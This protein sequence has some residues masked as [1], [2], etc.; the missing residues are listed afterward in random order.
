MLSDRNAENGYHSI[1]DSVP[2]CVEYQAEPTEA[3]G[4]GHTR[5]SVFVLLD[6]LLFRRP[7]WA[8]DQ[9]AST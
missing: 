2:H 5:L 4:Q 6:R 8:K 1:K 3:V 7:F 9:K